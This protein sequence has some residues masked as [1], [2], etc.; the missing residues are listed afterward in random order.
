[1][2]V[3]HAFIE[4]LSLS[5]Y[6]HTG[7]ILL[8]LVGG[9]DCLEI[10]RDAVNNMNTEDMYISPNSEQGTRDTEALVTICELTLTM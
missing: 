1:M 2:S 3:I 4:T 10:C 9:T 6:A 7:E 5:M 8:L